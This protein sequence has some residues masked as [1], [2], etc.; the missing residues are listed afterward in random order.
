MLTIKN[1]NRLKDKTFSSNGKE[2]L[3]YGIEEQKYQYRIIIMQKVDGIW[4]IYTTQYVYISREP[5][6]MTKESYGIYFGRG[7]SYIQLS[8]LGDMW[9]VITK[10]CKEDLIN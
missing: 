10:I 4:A 8:E 3:V 2:Y 6:V 1:T 7:K 9:N 5:L